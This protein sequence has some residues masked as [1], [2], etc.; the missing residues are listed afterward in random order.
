M[1]GLQTKL[2]NTKHN[3]MTNNNS[4][5]YYP[6]HEHDGDGS[7]GVLS[8]NEGHLVV[9]NNDA[10]NNIERTNNKSLIDINNNA[11]H[12]EVSND[13]NIDYNS[14]YNKGGR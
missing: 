7:L 8:N 3:N 5:D 6:S 1:L 12:N 9:E 13:N 14:L 4:V 2:N 10:A 11:K